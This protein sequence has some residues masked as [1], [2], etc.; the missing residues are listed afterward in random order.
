LMDSRSVKFY[1][2]RGGWK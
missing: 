2:S 1:W